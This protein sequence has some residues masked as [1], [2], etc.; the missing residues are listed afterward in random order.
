MEASSPTSNLRTSKSCLFMSISESRI[1]SIA[2]TNK[3]CDLLPLPRCEIG[4]EYWNQY[5]INHA[6]KAHQRIMAAIIWC[7]YI[8][9]NDMASMTKR[10]KEEARMK[11]TV[12]KGL[13]IWD[14]IVIT[15]YMWM[16]HILCSSACHIPLSK[17]ILINVRNV[18]K[19]N[20]IY[21]YQTIDKS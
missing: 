2:K 9:S 16:F 12:A 5:T 11:K 14:D 3:Y 6:G 13:L 21:R 7:L 18:S 8:I 17:I 20:T 1:P 19:L 4:Y 10:G 15:R